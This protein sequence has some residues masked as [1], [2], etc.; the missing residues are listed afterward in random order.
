MEIAR[1]EAIL[2]DRDPAQAAQLAR[3]QLLH[4]GT[5]EERRQRAAAIGATAATAAKGRRRKQILR[6]LLLVA[7]AAG[8]VPLGQALLRDQARAEALT[9]RLSAL[10]EPVS[11]LGLRQV[12]A[13]LA[14]PPAGVTVQVRANACAALVATREGASAA[15]PLRLQRPGAAPLTAPAGVLW[16]AC[17]AEAVE[18]TLP[19]GDDARA[20]LVLMSAPTGAT[21][22]LEVLAE[23]PVAGFQLLGGAPGACS[24]AGFQAWAER[25]GNGDP[26][27][28]APAREGLTAE[29]VADGFEAAGL[30]ESDRGFGVLRAEKGHCYL[31]VAE[32]RPTELTLRGPDGAPLATAPGGAVA[33]CSYAGNA[34]FSLWRAAKGSAPI[35]VVRAVA[36]RAGGVLG[37][38]LAA[39]RHGV[40]EVASALLPAEL[41]SDA[42][43][44]LLAAGSLSTT[45]HE[46]GPAG[47]PGEPEARA[48]AF[49]LRGKLAMLPEV[50]PAVATACFPP[51]EGD[52]PAPASVCAQARGQVWR[53]TGD[54]QDQG[55]VEGARPFWLGVLE[56]AAEEG[57]LRAVA[58]LM[59]FAQR[60][61]LLGYEPTTTEGVKDT[62]EGATITGRPGTS[63]VVAVGLSRS[64]PWIVPLTDG[65]RWSLAGAPRVVAIAPGT[66]KAVHGALRLPA[67]GKDR[68][69]VVWRR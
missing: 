2:H 53:R 43:A 41:S 60:M 40:S 69:V 46:A 19:G 37:P 26:A 34:A 49:S 22:G 51:P 11:R 66:T 6:G 38:L 14:V 50:S 12:G 7:L 29:L 48:A 33:W 58:E 1:A 31:A 18:V 10:R 59:V 20:A 21:G 32:R 67:E 13:W 15:V 52:R 65:P 5:D 25:E 8:A 61:T 35:V 27:P 56:G 9:Q 4:R 17:E 30:L 57:A 54:P 24:G 42:R 16:C 23:R 55:A 63:G 36:E 39:R 68:R 64:R 3:A 44:Q 28:L 47:L 45:V 62:A